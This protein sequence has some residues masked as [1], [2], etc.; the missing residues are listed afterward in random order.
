MSN[1]VRPMMPSDVHEHMREVVEADVL[2]MT[3]IVARLLDVERQRDHAQAVTSQGSARKRHLKRIRALERR[4]AEW[5]EAYA[6]ARR[7]VEQTLERRARIGAVVVELA[8]EQAAAVDRERELMRR[9]ERL[10]R[11]M[12]P[13]ALAA[14]ID[15]LPP[16]RLA[17]RAMLDADGRLLEVEDTPELARARAALEQMRDD[18]YRARRDSDG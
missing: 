1:A 6:N 9:L 7:Y 15:D 4:A 5:Q 18:A 8:L 16:G 11:A 3:A 14:T 12:F 2:D 17:G 13:P 10:E